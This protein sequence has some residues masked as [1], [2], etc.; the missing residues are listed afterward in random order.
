MNPPVWRVEDEGEV[1]FPAS[2]L[3][4]AGLVSLPFLVAAVRR[5]WRR[6][7]A[8]AGVGAVLALGVM[9]AGAGQQ[10]VATAT[11]LLIG[12]PSTDPSAAMTTNE[13]FLLTRKVSEEVVSHLDLPGSPEDFRATVAAAPVSDQLLSVTVT[14]PS[15]HEALRRLTELASVYL[16][17]RAHELSVLAD[18]TINA[19]Q[20]R[21]DNLNDQIAALTKQIDQISSTP[22]QQQAASD[23]LTERAQLQAV[24]TSADQEIE[25]IRIANQAI[26]GASHVVDDAAIVHQP[27]YKRTLLAIVSGL[28]GGTALGLGL[29]LAP[30]VLSTRLRRRDDVARALGIPVRFSAGQV[31]SRW[32]WFPGQARRNAERLA[33]GLATALPDDGEVARLAVATIGD[34]G[35][36]A[37]VIGALADQLASG[38]TRVGVVDLS[39]TSALARPSRFRLG[40]RDPIRNRQLV[41]VHRQGV[42]VSELASRTRISVSSDRDLSKAQVILTLIELDL[43]AGVDALGELADA[44]VVLVGAGSASAERLRSSATLL[45]QSDIQPAFAMLVGADV[46]DESSGLLEPVDAKPQPRRWSS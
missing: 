31:R 22:G 11:L 26:V 16:G 29:V 42:R 15:D 35:D 41:R 2:S 4:E 14:A 39:S 23:L 18:S 9:Q 44:L 43:G 30:A 10:H 1:Q 33:H 46:T 38:S 13:G 17:F 32:W 7:M 3:T 12:D 20:Q 27:Q 34:V 36:G 40:R 6:I 21:L 25:R 24:A 28:I 19:N 8:V 45:R 37:Y 5:R